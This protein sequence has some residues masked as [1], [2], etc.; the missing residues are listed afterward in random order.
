MRK[1]VQKRL[2]VVAFCIIA[3]AT[4]LV[5]RLYFVQ[6]VHGDEFSERAGA[7]YVRSNHNLYDRGSI[8]MQAENDN[9]V[10]AATLKEGYL[11]AL[12]PELL[13]GEDL[14]RIYSHLSDIIDL[15]PE[16]FYM[17][18][19]KSDD[20]YEEIA[21]RIPKSK[22]AKI[23]DL[24]VNGVRVYKHR[25]RH[26]PGNTLAAHTVGFTGYKGDV[27]TGRYGLERSYNDVLQRN[28]QN[29]YVNFFAELFANIKNSLTNN[30]SH[31][32]GDV[33]T[34]LEPSVQSFLENQLRQVHTEWNSRLTA[35]VIMDPQTGAIR[36]MAARPTFNPN[37]YGTVKNASVYSNPLVE[38][39]YELGSIMKPLTMAAGIDN[40]AVSPDTE[41]TDE[42]TVTLNGATI[43]NYD[44]EARGTVDMQTVLNESLNTGAVFVEQQM[45]NETFAEYMDRFG[46]NE[47]TG[48]DLP[49]EAR[50]MT[51]NLE[52]KRDIEYATAAFGQGIAVSP[53]AMTRALSALA[54]E[55]VLVTPHVGKRIKYETGLSERIEP[56]A[57][58]GRR[59][60]RETASDT[61]TRMLVNVVDEA[62]K[63]G[64]VKL[65]HHRV[66]A[67]T[68][69]A[70]IPDPNEGGYYE[71][72]YLHSFF[73]YF[74]ARDPQFLIFL[75]T[76]EPEG[77][78]YASQTLT[79][80]FMQSVQFLINYYDVPPGR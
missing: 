54:N 76:V 18:A 5:G 63:N 1:T 19:E 53:I 25:W 10:P 36:A 58:K 77:V 42:G 52:S 64:E 75:M 39:V 31:R 38:H 15:A 4:L 43:S 26:Y 73:G 79:T 35:G 78:R 22:A 55:G 68:G 80:P 27:L 33:V 17:H 30:E 11:V 51:D 13:Q 32:A 61:I 57:A 40:G 8:F 46:L 69:T 7:Q 2:Y 48:I 37:E 50:G 59:V 47:F 56:D 20:P 65:P 3:I 34:T 23:R 14:D 24:D 49:N 71:D 74:P 44:G 66:A 12:N 9:L 6:I 70:Q 72:K 21:H 16:E 45:G 62:L 67:K 60:M 29:L 41:Y 28:A